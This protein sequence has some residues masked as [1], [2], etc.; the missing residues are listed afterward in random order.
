MSIIIRMLALFGCIVSVA[1]SAE[2]MDSAEF[3]QWRPYADKRLLGSTNLQ[4]SREHWLRSKLRFSGKTNRDSEGLD[5]HVGLSANDLIWAQHVAGVNFS[6]RTSRKDANEQR[7]LDFRYSFPAGRSH[8]SVNLQ[9]TKYSHTADSEDTRFLAGG[10]STTFGL[11]GERPVASLYNVNIDSVFRHTRRDNRS[12][13]RGEWVSESSYQLSTFGLKGHRQYELV[14]GIQASSHVLALGGYE[15]QGTDYRYDGAIVEEDPFHKVSVSASLSRELLHWQW[16]VDGRYQ[17]GSGELPG[18]EHLLIA[19]PAMLSGYNGQSLSVI[20][21]GWVRLDTRSPSY[22]VPFTRNILSSMRLSVVKGWASDIPAQS[23][24]HGKASTG[25]VS[26]HLTGRD[27][28]ADV[29]VGRMLNSSNEA[30]TIP[31]R[32]DVRLSLSMDI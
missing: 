11:T 17:Y 31:D 10:E 24:R 29:S 2:S 19:G 16:G 7:S 25:Q 8:I 15:Y 14:K 30:L 21:G 26:V 32:P 12:L 18:S 28:V 4:E 27:F 9:N 1:A 6:D 3:G 13:E 20:E 5:G 23:D 22:P